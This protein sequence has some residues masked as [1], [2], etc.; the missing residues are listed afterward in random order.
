MPAPAA[1]AVC[2]QT[3]TPSATITAGPRS[4]TRSPATPS[5]VVALTCSRP[6]G[7][8]T[9]QTSGAWSRPR[10]GRRVPRRPHRCRTSGSPP[11]RARRPAW[12]ACP[13]AAV[14]AWSG[15]DHLDVAAERRRRVE[16]R[17]D[18]SGRAPRA[19]GSTDSATTTC[20]LPTSTAQA[21]HG[22]IAPGA[23]GHRCRRRRR[24]P[25]R[26]RPAATAQVGGVAR[27][28][29]ALPAGDPAHRLHPA[30]G[31]DGDLLAVRQPV[32]AAVLEVGGEHPDPVAAHLGHRAVGVAVVHEPAFTVV[33]DAQHTVATDPGAPV[34][35]RART[36]SAV[37][38]SSPSGSCSSTKS[39]S[40]PWPLAQ[41]LPA[42]V[43]GPPCH[44]VRPRRVRRH[45]R[46][47]RRPRTP[48]DDPQRRGD[49]A[50]VVVSQ[51]GD[52]RV[53]AEPG[54]LA[55]GEPAGGGH[56]SLAGLGLVDP[57][58]E[59]VEHL[60]V[61]ERPGRGP[62]LAPG[63]G[64]AGSPPRRP[65]RSAHIRCTRTLDPDDPA[66]GAAWSVRAARSGGGSDA[67]APRARSR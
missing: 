39:F 14:V 49:Q 47:R 43:I 33:D 34:A 60:R 18:G 48:T 10:P 44:G 35:Q 13:A 67:A 3:S 6:P 57:P 8:S 63:R 24:P 4:S 23:G 51:P 55:T 30:P 38:S 37:R 19:R 31:G 22:D 32:Q 66:P 53:P 27:R 17:G 62:P 36:C 12:S 45:G 58:G 16:R 25:P 46:A 11:R 41:R 21:G 54:L 56:R 15:H 9:S 29:T 26:R 50:G 1:G 2:R 65:G 59:Q 7:T 64:P 52:P 61:A 28:L 40:V 20:G 5:P 42:S